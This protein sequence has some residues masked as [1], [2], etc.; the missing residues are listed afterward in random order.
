MWFE[1]KL[2]SDV[3]GAQ[4]ERPTMLVDGT[5]DLIQRNVVY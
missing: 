5:L 2:R 1:K 4:I 3:S